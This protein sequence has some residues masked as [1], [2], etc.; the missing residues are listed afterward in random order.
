MLLVLQKCY[1]LALNPNLGGLLGVCLNLPE[2]FVRTILLVRTIP[3]P[4]NLVRKCTHI[5]GFRKYTF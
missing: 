1:L 3:E 4:W 2:L 5:F